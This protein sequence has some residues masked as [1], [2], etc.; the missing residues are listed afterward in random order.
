MLETPHVALGMAIAVAVPNPFISIPLSFASH[1]LLDMAPHW[2]P[3]LNTETKKYGHLTTGTLLIIGLD[4]ASTLL[5]TGFAYKANFNNIN[6]IYC[7]I[8]SILPDLLEAP[9]YIFG[10][11]NKTLEIW[12]Q[13]QI[14]IQTDANVFWGMLTQIIVLLGALYIIT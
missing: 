2:N 5:L 6:L 12:R 9:Y 14:A 3:H 11:K 7:A 13:F 10:F 8:S 4:V 1:F